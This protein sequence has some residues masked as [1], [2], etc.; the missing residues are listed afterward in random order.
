M[1]RYD[2]VNDTWQ[3]HATMPMPRHGPAAAAI[4]DMIYTVAGAPWSAA[5]IDL[6][7]QQRAGI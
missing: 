7:Q 2:P 1:E 3:H 5:E 6:S 4:G